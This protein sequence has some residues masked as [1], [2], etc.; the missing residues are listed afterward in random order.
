MKVLFLTTILPITPRSGGEIVS[1]LYI[2]NLMALGYSVDVLG[3]LRK[4][5]TVEIPYNMHLAKKIVIE[6]NTSK[7]F[8]LLNIAKSY[9]FNRCYSAQK[10]ITK[11]YIKLIKLFLSQNDYQLVIIDHFQMG[12]VLKY[13]P[14]GSKII[15]ISHNMESDLYEQLSRSYSRNSILHYIYKKEAKKMR[16]IEKQLMNSSLFVW[17]LTS[18]NRER[19]RQLL[20]N[21]EEKMKVVCIPPSNISSDFYMAGEEKKWDIGILGTWTWKANN[22]GLKWFFEEVYPLLSTSISIRVAGLGADWLLNKYK[23]V[24]YVG[25]VEDANR[26]MNNSKVIA[27]PSIAG[28]G[29]QIKTIQAISLGQKIVAT[30]FA[31]RGIDNLPVYVSQADSPI[32]FKEKLMSMIY[33]EEQDYR[34]DAIYWCNDRKEQFINSLVF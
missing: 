32:E 17:M 15:S 9:I 16:L 23:N 22:D 12:W 6:S 24:L 13:L 8:T 14:S 1:K 30:S 27:I 19:Y 29:I 7:L 10:Y 21:C 31:L 4:G 5:D 28:D 33:M 20:S 2:D 26:F 18:D 34:K 11:E 25:F 3:Y